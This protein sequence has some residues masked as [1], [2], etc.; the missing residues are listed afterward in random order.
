[1]ANNYSTLYSTLED[2]KLVAAGN[3]SARKQLVKEGVNW[4]IVAEIHPEGNKFKII[5]VT[6]SRRDSFVPTP[7][8][9]IVREG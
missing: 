3:G 2:A 5:A 4:V 7:N 6:V 8:K 9:Y 1:M